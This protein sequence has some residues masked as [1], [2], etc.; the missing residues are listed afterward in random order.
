MGK[1]VTIITKLTSGSVH[2]AVSRLTELIAERGMKLFAL[3]DHAAEARTVGLELRDTVVV[4][5]GSPAGGTPIMVAAPTAALDLPLRILVWDDDG[6]TKITYVDPVE[7]AARYDLNPEL[8]G[9]LAGIHA[10]A[11]AMAST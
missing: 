1:T 4:L 7:L 8:A 9:R 10:L 6:Q 5:F 11:D 3:I 2:D